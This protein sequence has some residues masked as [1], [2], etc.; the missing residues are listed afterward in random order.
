MLRTCS[1][2]A[3]FKWFALG[4]ALAGL[5]GC[6]GGGSS[7]TG[8]TTEPET[9]VM[10]TLPPGFDSA[11]NITGQE[12]VEGRIESAGDRVFYKIRIDEPSLLTLRV[13]GD[14]DITVYDSEGNVVEPLPAGQNSAAASMGGEALVVLPL[15]AYPIA[16]A[17]TIYVSATATKVVGYALAAVVATYLIYQVADLAELRVGTDGEKSHDLKMFFQGE[18]VEETSW[19]ITP[20]VMTKWG[21]MSLTITDDGI[22]RASHTPTTGL[23]GNG[24][25]RTHELSFKV[26][27][28]WRQAGIP[29]SDSADQPITIAWETAPRR[30]GGAFDI[31]AS[32]AEGKSKTLVLTEYI[33]DPNGD[34]RR[35]TFAVSGRIPRGW[36]VTTDGPRM[37]FSAV[38]G[39]ADSMMTVTATDSD[40][41]CWN[42]PV[43]VRIEEEEDEEEPT[44]TTP[45]TPTPPPM[46]LAP[47]APGT[48]GYG[49]CQASI[50]LWRTGIDP[51]SP[52]SAG[53]CRAF[54]CSGIGAG[55]TLPD[56]TE[57]CSCCGLM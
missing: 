6:G 22:L 45:T 5:A 47:P 40:G 4:I 51:Q 9:I 54:Y 39:A 12:T 57:I 26:E 50:E 42:F 15:L 3:R 18:T 52:T 30:T 8:G 56:G 23:C 14:V 20:Y 17:G 29:L 44:P 33:G 43:S 27:Y 10:P 2:I 49:Y 31:S 21:R 25:D 48:S 7:T 35:L 16:K 19:S 46:T 11:V 37:T 41:E 55:S 1:V 24:T 13:T 38:K 36:G 53:E 28:S 32:V 34:D